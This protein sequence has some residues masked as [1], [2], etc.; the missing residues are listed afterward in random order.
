MVFR[1]DFHVHTVYSDDSFNGINLL[2]KAQRKGYHVAITDHNNFRGVKIARRL[3]LKFIPGI[4]VTTDKGDMIG[5]YMNEDGQRYSKGMDYYEMIDRV[6]EDD[7]LTVSPHPFDWVRSNAVKDKGLALS[8]DIIEGYNS[9]SLFE[10][11]NVRA[12]KLAVENNKPITVGSDAHFPIE[13]WNSYMI[14]KDEYGDASDS[15]F[16][17]PKV[18]LKVLKNKPGYR[19]RQTFIFAPSLTYILKKFYKKIVPNRY[20]RW[21][22]RATDR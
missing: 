22:A 4:E 19:I 18:L 9:R 14:I 10:S 1:I 3:G 20:M 8:C 16:N 7:G 6:K 17:N 13:L 5:L 11:A 15:I 2:I 21:G 12:M